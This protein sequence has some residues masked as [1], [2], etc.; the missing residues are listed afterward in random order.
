MISHRGCKFS[1][2]ERGSSCRAVSQRW[3]AGIPGKV[4]GGVGDTVTVVGGW[5]AL[6]VL[7]VGKRNSLPFLQA[8]PT[9]GLH[10]SSFTP[11]PL[12]ASKGGWLFLHR[13]RNDRNSQMNSALGS[14][15]HHR[16]LYKLMPRLPICG[17]ASPRFSARPFAAGAV[18]PYLGTCYPWGVVVFTGVAWTLATQVRG[19]PWV[20]LSRIQPPHPHVDFSD[21]L[22]SDA[23]SCPPA[24]HCPRVSEPPERALEN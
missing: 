8:A 21:S 7:P 9:S 18:S 1:Q 12:A 17:M 16:L 23:S 19:L 11:L 13:S 15:S 14:G 3:R 22:L 20:L 5:G 2:R 4:L 10:L 6:N 24:P